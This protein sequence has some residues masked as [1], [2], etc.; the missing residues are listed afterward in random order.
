[1]KGLLTEKNQMAANYVGWGGELKLELGGQIG[2]DGGNMFRWV[3]PGSCFQEPQ[4]DSIGTDPVMTTKCY[5]LGIVLS[6]HSRV[7]QS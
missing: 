5:A 2:Y 7:Y 6:S 4:Y 3:N 1:M